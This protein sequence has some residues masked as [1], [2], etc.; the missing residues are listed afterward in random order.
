MKDVLRV[1]VLL[2]SGWAIGFSSLRAGEAAADLPPELGA[3]MAARH[4]AHLDGDTK[5]VEALM[6]DDYVQTDVSGRVQ[7]RAEWL[8]EYFEPLAALIRSGRF[9]WDVWEERIDQTRRLGDAAVVVVGSMTLKGIG[10]T[11][12]PGKGWVA[13]PRASFGPATLR[14]TRI[15]TRRD[16]KWLLAAVHNALVSDTAKK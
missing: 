8:S 1:A 10:A 14:F 11:P 16:G 5:A 4:K 2:A 9:R 15:W 6:T 3:A 7:G 13:S 12:V